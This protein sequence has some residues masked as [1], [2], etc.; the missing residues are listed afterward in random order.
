MASIRSHVAH[1]DAALVLV[2]VIV[3]VA[4]T[5]RRIA[6]LLAAFGAGVWFDFFLTEPTEHFTINDHHDI[7][8]TLLLLIVG[9]A[10]T[11]L[12][13]WGRRQESVVHRQ[14]EQLT[15]LNLG[16]HLTVD[17][18]SPSQLIEQ[19]NQRLIDLLELRAARFRY[20]PAT[21]PAR[22]RH[23]GVITVA[24]RRWDVDTRGLPTTTP[25][26]LDAVAG[27][28]PWGSFVLTATPGTHPSMTDRLVAVAFAD[29]VGA[30]LN[31]YDSA[32]DESELV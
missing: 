16:A 5:G 31:E 3:A 29:Q 1:T 22:L 13:V 4:T 14:S 20:T 27:G 11:E 15:E 24:G 2:V 6:G 17:G 30:I 28:K 26:E 9:A 18:R 19:V 12:A 23:D 25:I 32:R 10:V 8:T 7:E 21:G